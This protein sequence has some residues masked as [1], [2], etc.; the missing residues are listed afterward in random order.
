[1]Q[2]VVREVKL[3]KTGQDNDEDNATDDE[4]F[5]CQLGGPNEGSFIA[6]CQDNLDNDNDGVRSK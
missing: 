4:D 2:H 6:H 3:E 5:A 1:M